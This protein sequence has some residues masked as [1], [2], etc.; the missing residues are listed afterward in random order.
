M[1]KSLLVLCLASALGTSA[2]A[3]EPVTQQQLEALEARIG[4][5]EADAQAMR[6]QTADALAQA[7]AA[8]AELARIKGAAAPAVEDV[9]AT[10][11]ADLAAPPEDLDSPAP[12]PD[13]PDTL[14]SEDSGS[15]SSGGGNAFNPAITIILNGSY[16]HH[17]LNPDDYVRAGFPLAGEAG[18]GAD[19]LSLG[20]SEISFAANIDDK[21]Y[22]QLT[23]A[24]ESEDGEDNIGVEEAF[25]DTTALPGGFT[26]RAGRFFSNIGYLNSHHAHTD[27]FSDR[28]LAYQAFVGSQYGDDGV[29]LRWVAPTDLFMEFGGEVFRGQNFP[30]GGAT[31]GGVGAKTLF[32]HLGG[33]VGGENSWLA[34]VS[35]LK[36]SAEGADDGFSGD[37]T[38]YLADATWKW[39]P[40]GNFKDGGVTLRG[41]YFLDD[42]DGSVI[43]PIDPTV[44]TLW[45][46][47]RRGAYLESVYR[48]NRTWD[49]GY[50]YDKLWAAG[51]GPFASDF[52]PWRHSAV[53]TWRNSEFSLVRLQLSHD[54]PN[55]SDTDNAVTLQYQTSLGAH[56]AHKF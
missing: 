20:E 14:A 6:K 7:Q 43:D 28:P 24:V 16:A 53:L 46:G 9:A 36:S 8:Q 44:S 42:R 37:S 47:E 13:A 26:L 5:L 45:N 31:H 34:G 27:S 19:G 1:K 10:D 48:F 15:S 3:A 41:E 4:Q 12:A 18:P 17:S 38:L 25:I 39:A 23:L 2:Y 56:G 51:T 54:K 11:D 35:M 49:V 55:A 50:R 30:S 21:L 40:Q 22:G 29:Q 32:A 52:D 33:D